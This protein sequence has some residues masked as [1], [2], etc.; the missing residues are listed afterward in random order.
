MTSRP[1]ETTAKFIGGPADGD[2][3][4]TPGDEEVPDFVRVWVGNSAHLYV[5][6]YDTE[7]DCIVFLHEP[8]HLELGGESLAWLQN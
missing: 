8:L 6:H 4:L 3:K 7:D 1:N 2:T 5:S